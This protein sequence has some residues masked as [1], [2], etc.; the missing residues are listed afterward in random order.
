ME[1]IIE[2]ITKALLLIFNLDRETYQILWLSLKIST[3]ATLISSILGV[4]I[5][6]YISSKQFKFKNTLITFINTGMAMPPVL[7]GLF[8]T[9]L[10][11]RNGILG[12]FDLLYTPAA[13][14]I[15]Q[16]FLATPIILGIS[17]AAFQGFSEKFKLQ[18]LGL[19]ASR[20]QLYLIMIRELKLP[21]LSAIMAGFGGIISEVGASMMVG[22]NIKGYTRVLTTAIV[23]ETGK[24]NFDLALAY[25]FVLLLL[26]FSINM[27][28]TK[29]QQSSVTRHE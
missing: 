16:I 21:I 24:G 7:A 22:G 9:I 2:S 23:A 8:I 19:G 18:I 4:G 1:L 27:I 20:L 3:V 26:S 15:A 28:L 13:I 6:L 25:G 17:L 14:I 5:A 10:L 11:W 29:I 12:R